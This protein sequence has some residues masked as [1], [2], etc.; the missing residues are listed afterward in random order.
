[1]RRTSRC[2]RTESP[3]TPR[4]TTICQQLSREIAHLP[5]VKLVES[6]VGVAVVPLEHDGAP[7]LNPSINPAGSVNGLYFNEDRATPVVGRMADPRRADEFVTTA[8]GSARFGLARGSGRSHGRVLIKPVRPAGLRHA[9][10]GTAAQ[11]RHEA[12]RTRRLQRPGDRGRRR[13]TPHRRPV[14]PRTDP[15]ADHLQLPSRAPGTPCNSHTET[16]AF[17]RS[18]RSS[19]TCS[20]VG[21]MPTSPSPQSPRPRWSEPSSQSRS[22]SACSGPLPR[23]R[24]W[25]SGRSPYP[26]SCARTETDLSVLRALGASPATTVADG[27]V[28]VLGAIVSGS[29]LAVAVAISLS[30]LSP[31]GPIRAVYH[32]SAIAVDWT[33][34]GFGASRADWRA[35]RDRGG[36]GLPRCSPPSGF[37]IPH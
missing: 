36:A 20:R 7:N 13:P 8:S 34:L 16:V 25:P 30:P 9:K 24:R 26:G 21:A 33:V 27:L 17:P 18:K 2:R 22:H 28:G 3:A 19:S 29:L 31:L 32:P 23:W 4:R 14:H 12:G 10:R 37:Q 5:E 6:W 15:H 11:D 35:R 1:M